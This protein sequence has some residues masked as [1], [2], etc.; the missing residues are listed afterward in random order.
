VSCEEARELITE[1]AL[2]IADGAERARALEHVA[3]CVDC[4]RELERVSQV[5][6]QLLELTPE[7]EPP[8]GFELRVLESLSP[9]ATVRRH[10][11]RALLALAAAVAAAAVTA[12][13]LLFGLRDDQRLADHYRA[14]LTE[15]HGSYFGAARLH[16]DAGAEGGTLF[17]Y[18][19]SPSWLMVT[20]DERHRGSAD[21]VA[22]T[23][24]NGA[25]IPL[26]WARFSDGAWGGSLP[27]DLDAVSTVRVLRADG[28]IV[29]TAD[30]AR[31]TR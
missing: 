6:D 16:D 2:G 3:V 30:L 17:V 4:Q 20:V 12:G 27:V 19:G 18:R 1:L 22:L 31:A 13:A 7:V 15:A 8:V 26:S 24:R 25:E 21:R 11:P 29:L 14:T 10:A 23:D 28:S 5:A 9:R